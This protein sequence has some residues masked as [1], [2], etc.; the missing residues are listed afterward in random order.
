MG[1]DSSPTLSHFPVT[2][3]YSSSMTHHILEKVCSESSQAHKC[4]ES[5]T[6]LLNHSP[7]DRGIPRPLARLQLPRPPDS[8]AA[9]THIPI[10]FFLTAQVTC[11]IDT[12]TPP[13]HLLRPMPLSLHRPSITVSH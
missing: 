3:R 1:K 8:P 10:T 12:P 7:M 4:G 13:I 5:W 2:R 11:T 9:S 6:H